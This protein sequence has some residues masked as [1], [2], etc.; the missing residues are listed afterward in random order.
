MANG[1][2]GNIFDKPHLTLDKL[3][4][5]LNVNPEIKIIDQPIK[6]E[7]DAYFNGTID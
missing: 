5:K 1:V 4:V 7:N 2:V 6:L 3:K